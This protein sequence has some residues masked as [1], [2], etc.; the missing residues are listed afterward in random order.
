MLFLPFLS[1]RMI[2][3]LDGVKP[4]MVTGMEAQL[5]VQCLTVLTSSLWLAKSH[6]RILRE[7]WML[8]GWML[9]EHDFH[10]FCGATGNKHST[11]KLKGKSCSRYQKIFGR[12]EV[13]VN[14]SCRTS[15][16]FHSRCLEKG[17]LMQQG[18]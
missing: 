13:A 11:W 10:L 14:A 1:R 16:D 9:M 7:W 5:L 3:K 2:F 4:T 8:M 12:I 18:L 17:D 15:A 6:S